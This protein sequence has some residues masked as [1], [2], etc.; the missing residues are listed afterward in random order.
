[1]ITEYETLVAPLFSLALFV[2]AVVCWDIAFVFRTE[3]VAVVS[4]IVD[5]GEL[6]TGIVSDRVLVAVS[7]LVL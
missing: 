6:E 3:R 5:T 7:M 4:L 1:M 2:F